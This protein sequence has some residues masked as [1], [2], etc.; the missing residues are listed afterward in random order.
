MATPFT[1]VCSFLINSANERSEN[2]IE[3]FEEE[4]DEKEILM[5]ISKILETLVSP[6]EYLIKIKG[7]KGQDTMVIY[8]DK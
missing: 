5:C 6:T 7:T 2:N 4:D 3:E 8:Q 1:S